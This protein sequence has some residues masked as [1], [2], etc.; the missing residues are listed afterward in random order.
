MNPIIQALGRRLRLAV[1]GGGPG[2]FIGQVHRTAARIDDRFELVAGVLSSN[3]DRSRAAAAEIGIAADRAYADWRG[4]ID[5]EMARDDGA[6]VVAV[7]TPNDTH[8]PIA[9]ACLDSG[10]HV[11]CD[12]PLTTRMD[13]AMKLVAKVRD[14]GLIFCL[15]HNYSAYPM[16]RQA[17]AMVQA[18][19]IGAV[20]QVQLEYIQGHLAARVEDQPGGPGWRFDPET[21]GASLVLG[22]IGTHAH[23]LGAY[24]TGLDLERVMADVGS[25]VPGREADDYAAI[26]SRYQGGARGSMWVTNSAAGGEHGLAFRIFGETGGLEWHQEEPNT[27]L[28]RRH[29]DFPRRLTRRLDGLLTPEAERASRIGIG[30][31]EGYQEAFANLYANAAEAIVARRTGR[32]CDPLAMDFPTALDGAKGMKFIEAAVESSRTGAWVDCRLET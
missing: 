8:Y 21:S 6:E 20:R 1:I 5:A 16:V 9:N 14:T 7:M 31:P 10:L 29:G 17:R 23:H 2:S 24:V 22:D 26:L 4:L 25:C 19:E 28:H 3:A 13:D 32:P 18:G 30:H 11:I 12:K 15:T 27:L